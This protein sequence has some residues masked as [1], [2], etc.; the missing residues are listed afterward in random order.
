MT[1][2][3]SIE[4][5]QSYMKAEARFLSVER[6]LEFKKVLEWVERGTAEQNLR[7]LWIAEQEAIEKQN[8][9]K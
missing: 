8:H 5:I 2:E 3:Y 7:S 9:D 4:M 6:Y 1:D